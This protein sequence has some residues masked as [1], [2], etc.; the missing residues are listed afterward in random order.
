MS[1]WVLIVF[2]KLGY[3]GGA[4]SQEFSDRAA[5][6]NALTELKKSV[7]AFE[8]GVCVPKATGRRD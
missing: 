3:A 2:F 7:P 4:I 6:I 8:G 5:C 1:L